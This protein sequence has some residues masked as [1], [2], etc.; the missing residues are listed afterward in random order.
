VVTDGSKRDIRRKVHELFEKVGKPGGYICS[1][2][3]HFFETPPEKLQAFAE[4]ARECVY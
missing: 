2:S 4:A 3:D 1:L